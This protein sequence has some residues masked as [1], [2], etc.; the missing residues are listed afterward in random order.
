MAFAFLC[1]AIALGQQLAKASIG[2]AIC[3][4]GENLEAID[5][6]QPRADHKLDAFLFFHSS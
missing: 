5:G 1:L 2:L 3:R 4:I 6:D